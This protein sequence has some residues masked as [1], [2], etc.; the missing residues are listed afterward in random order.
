M[1]AIR[2]PGSLCG[3]TLDGYYVPIIVLLENS[4]LTYIQYNAVMDDFIKRNAGPIV[5]KFG[6][7]IS[8]TEK[9]GAKVGH[10]NGCAAQRSCSAVVAE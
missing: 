1:K 2:H 9:R 4:N 6:F 8:A 3:G 7:Q 10:R 5:E